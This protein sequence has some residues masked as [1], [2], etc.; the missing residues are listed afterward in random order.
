MKT[1]FKENSIHFIIIGIFLVLVFFYF[2][3]IF[4]GKTLL[5]SDVVQAEGSQKE[6]FD[7]KAKDGQAPLW[8]NSMFGGMPTYQIW[9]EHANIVTTYFG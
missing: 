8:S 1:W 2:S 7:Y 4:G 3:P 9:H 5:Q 6:L